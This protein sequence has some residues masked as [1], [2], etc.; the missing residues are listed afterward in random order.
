MSMFR[1]LVY[2]VIAPIWMPFF[3]VFWILPWMPIML[4]LICIDYIIGKGDRLE[5]RAT[6]WFMWLD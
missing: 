3:F 1:R 5:S 6:R 2:I 4:T